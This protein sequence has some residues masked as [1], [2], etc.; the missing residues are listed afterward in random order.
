MTS[1][2]N[3]EETEDVRG[4]TEAARDLGRGRRLFSTSVL[5]SRPAGPTDRALP[6]PLPKPVKT[7]PQEHFCTAP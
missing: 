6:E 7:L 4:R 1:E 2:A 3:G 5:A